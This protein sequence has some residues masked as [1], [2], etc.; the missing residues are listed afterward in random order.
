MLGQLPSLVGGDLSG[1]LHVG[2]VAHE[3]S[4][5]VVRGVL[6][7]LVHPVL[8]GG[9]A[10][11]VGDVVGDD[12]TVGALVV[13]AGDGLE[14]LLACGVPQIVSDYG[15]LREY[16]DGCGILVPVTPDYTPAFGYVNTVNSDDVCQA[17]EKIW[18]NDKDRKIATESS[19]KRAR[20]YTWDKS[21]DMWEKL[22]VED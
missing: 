2:L 12:D 3:N 10:L 8:D 11:A 4:R 6:L 1:V 18:L 9:E 20:E 5:D 16:A 22:L 14:A 17:M 15:V 7:D 21:A 13:A 19:L